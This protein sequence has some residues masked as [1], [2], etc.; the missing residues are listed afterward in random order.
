MRSWRGTSGAAVLSLAAMLAGAVAGRAAPPR[1]TVPPDTVV[2]VRLDERLGSRESRPGQRFTATVSEDDRS[3][4]PL[5]TRFEGVLTEVERAGRDRPAVLDAEFRAA[6]LPDGQRVPIRAE[7]ASLAAEDVT[8]DSEGRLRARQRSGR[9]FDWKWV[10]YGA[11]AGAV[12]AAVFDGN[13][14]RGA[15]IGAAGGALYGYLRRNRDRSE[16]QDVVLQRGTEFG[17]L[18]TDE[19]VFRDRPGYRYAREFDPRRGDRYGTGEWPE[20]AAAGRIGGSGET[21]V[22]FEERPVEFPRGRPVNLNGELFV[23]LEPVARAAGMRYREDPESGSFL[24]YTPEGA[25]EGRVGETEVRRRDGPPVRLERAPVLLD[26]ELYVPLEFFSEAA[27]L[28][29]R[30][31]RDAIR[32]EAA[33]ER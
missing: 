13:I 25:V 8:R 19:V 30:E 32:L 31:E 23:P 6:V 16:F 18:L 26:G 29:V 15:L 17:I 7:L 3:G 2:R 4:F 14:L 24:L 11:G 20:E 5:G 27:G 12:L 28:R 33:A 22:W 9:R 21:R 1:A 10:G